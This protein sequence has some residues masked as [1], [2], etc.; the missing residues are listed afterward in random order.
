M[1]GFLSEQ[2]LRRLEDADLKICSSYRRIK[3][4]HN[5]R[6]RRDLAYLVAMKLTPEWKKK[7]RLVSYQ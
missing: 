6:V 2:E 5:R 4:K 1:D 7:K 3:I